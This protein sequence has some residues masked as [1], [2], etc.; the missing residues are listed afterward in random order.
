MQQNTRR[1]PIPPEPAVR[2]L[3]LLEWFIGCAL[4][5]PA[6]TEGLDVD[7]A[8]SNALAYASALMVAMK[9]PKVPG[10]I[11]AP[12]EEQM[13]RW[14]K[15]MARMNGATSAHHVKEEVPTK[16]PSTICPLPIKTIR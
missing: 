9:A 2:D 10:R 4:A 3:S 15:I 7:D 12:T 16:E 5:N 6:V 13:E 11:D 8:A 1:M 14:V